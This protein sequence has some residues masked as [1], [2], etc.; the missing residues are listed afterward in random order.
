VKIPYDVHIH[1]VLSPCADRE[2]TINNI[3]N[4]AYIKGLKIISITDHNACFNQRVAKK[5][6]ENLK[7]TY[8][9][10]IEVQTKEEV[11]LLCYFRDVLSAEKFGLEIYNSL[12]N[13][14][15]DEELFG[16]QWIC[17]ENDKII[18]KE[19]RFLLNSSSF[20]IEDIYKMMIKYNGVLVPAHIDKNR[21]SIISQMGF[22]P[23]NWDIKTVEISKLND[24]S[25]IKKIPFSKKYRILRN[26][27]AHRLSDINEPNYNIELDEKKIDA[28]IDKIREW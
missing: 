27:D 24:E 11:H 5:I 4:M 23:L 7:I 14:K 17:D 26:S 6:A 21:Y 15:I 8:I 16:E 2:N 22:I 1:S 28:F 12:P 25:Y 10:G 19:E 18:K 13:S 3:V 9:P 20:S